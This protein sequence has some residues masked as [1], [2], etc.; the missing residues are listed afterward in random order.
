ML[1]DSLPDDV[2]AEAERQ[3]M[4][5]MELLGHDTT[6]GVRFRVVSDVDGRAK[7]HADCPCGHGESGRFEMLR[8]AA[9]RP[10]FRIEVEVGGEVYY[11]T[12]ADIARLLRWLRLATVAMKSLREEVIRFA[13]IYGER[14]AAAQTEAVAPASEAGGRLPSA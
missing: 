13:G 10:W 8:P 6:R 4:E 1:V 9:L 12:D 5:M 7:L 3:A 2:L 14:D 11:T